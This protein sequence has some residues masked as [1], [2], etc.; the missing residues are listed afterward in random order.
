MPTLLNEDSSTHFM[1][2]L[3]TFLQDKQ[4]KPDRRDKQTPTNST[5][6][7]TCKI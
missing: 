4:P 7:L 2:Q 1:V 6:I 3:N 5:K